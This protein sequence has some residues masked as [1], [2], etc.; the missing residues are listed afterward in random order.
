[1]TSSTGHS[2]LNS[3][4]AIKEWISMRGSVTGCF[5]VYQDFFS[6]RSGVYRHVS[7]DA[8]GGHCVEIVTR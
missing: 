6:Y 1:L 7:G 5:V 2:K 4:T 8:A 3:R